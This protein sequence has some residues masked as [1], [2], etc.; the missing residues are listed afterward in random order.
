MKEQY[1]NWTN[2]FMES[3][4]NLDWKATLDTLDKNV[5]YYENPIDEP[6]KSFDEV[7]SL[8]NVGDNFI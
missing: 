5:E 8:W 7:I 4:K 6:C 3:W 1:L 2:K